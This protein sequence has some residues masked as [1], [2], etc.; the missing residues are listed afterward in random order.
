MIMITQ[1]LCHYRHCSIAVAW[2]D[3]VHTAEQVISEGEEL[4]NSGK[5]NRKCGLCSG[6]LTPEHRPSVFKTLE[7]ARPWLQ[8]F[9]AIQMAS[10]AALLN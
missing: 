8:A 9:E 5:I 4:Y 1:W 3:S 10:R 2:D 7:E 6:G